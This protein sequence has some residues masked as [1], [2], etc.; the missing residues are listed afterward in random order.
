MIPWNWGED[1][2]R[3]TSAAAALDALVELLEIRTVTFRDQSTLHQ[4]SCRWPQRHGGTDRSD[5]LDDHQ[6]LVAC[7]PGA[8]R[9]DQF[10]QPADAAGEAADLRQQHP[11]FGGQD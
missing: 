8:F 7:Q 1:D 5:S 9:L 11:R 3:F 6:V 4:R 2:V 10:F